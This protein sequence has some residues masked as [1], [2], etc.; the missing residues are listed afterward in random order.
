MFGK[1]DRVL[2]SCGNGPLHGVDQLPYIA[3]P[4]IGKEGLEEFRRKPLSR[5]PIPF[6][7]L[8]GIV[9]DQFFDIVR[10]LSQRRQLNSKG[11]ET[12]QQL[13]AKLPLFN[14]TLKIPIGRNH[15]PEIAR[16]FLFPP[17][18][19]KTAFL[20]DTEERTLHGKRQFPYLI[21]KEGPPIGLLNETSLR[22]I[23]SC[24]CASLVPKEHAFH[25]VFRQGG[26]VD[27]D[28]ILV[29]TRAI[30]MDCI[31]KQFFSRAGFAGNKNV[32]VAIGR[33]GH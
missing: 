31:G 18:G 12:K 3:R 27:N 23:R 1:E 15:Q 9:Q 4:V 22:P 6:T 17:D 19:T 2:T 20:K 21:E 8:S 29:G 25:K 14:H 33:L 16:D 13:F 26:T 5:R 11:P 24:K 32:G 28:K 30:V 10:V 7:N